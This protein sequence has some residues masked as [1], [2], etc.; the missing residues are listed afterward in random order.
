MNPDPVPF[1]PVC[2]TAEI[3]NG[4][5]KAFEIEGVPILVVNL[6]RQFYA[7]QN[8]C[9][10]LD[11]PLAG[12]RQMGWEIM[13]RQHGARF[14]IRTGQALGGPAVTSVAVYAVRVVEGM[15]EV[16]VPA[17]R[18]SAIGLG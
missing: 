8:R 5:H 7:M 13:C 3:P 6:N 14:D 15:V 9:T 2:T 17:A 1:V 16:A 10:H 12:G 4:G 18:Q 11:Y